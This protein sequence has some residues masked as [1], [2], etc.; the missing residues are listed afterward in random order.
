MS[1]KPSLIAI[2]LA[3]LV[4]AGSAA[5]QDS[6]SPQAQPARPATV[7]E[8]ATFERL[9]PLARSVAWQREREL[10]PAD[11][12]A[13]VKVAEALRQLGQFDQA[14]QAAEQVLLIQPNNTEAMLEVGRA[15]IARGQAFYGIAA[16][17]KA[18]AAM[19]Q[20]WRPLS[21]LGV[22]YNQVRRPADAQAAWADGLKLSPDNPDILTNAAIALMSDGKAAEAEPLLRRAVA[23][24]GSTLKMRQNLALVIGLQGHLD[25]AEQMLRRDLPPDQADRNLEWLRARVSVA[26]PAGAAGPAMARTWGSIQA[27]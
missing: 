2:T 5:A 24:P 13:G 19:P 8:R 14:A 6:V 20:D 10:N 12:V 7:A 25:E 21:L 4:I 22:A 9:D 17:E 23:Q 27:Q 11:P 3:G 18:R 15:H 26:P 16:L 1:P